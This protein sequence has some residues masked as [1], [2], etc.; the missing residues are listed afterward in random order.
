MRQS[1]FAPDDSGRVELTADELELARDIGE[2]HIVEA[3]ASREQ[4]F[5]G[6]PDGSEASGTVWALQVFAT[7]LDDLNAEILQRGT[8]DA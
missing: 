1:W 5:D 2:V 6:I 4:L 3:A 8:R 7:G